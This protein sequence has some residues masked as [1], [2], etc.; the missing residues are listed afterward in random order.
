MGAGGHVPG[1]GSHQRGRVPARLPDAGRGESYTR[2]VL[3]GSGRRPGRRRLLLVCAALLA[4]LG[5]A[6][7]GGAAPAVIVQDSFSRTVATGLGSAPTGGPYTV[8]GKGF[9]VDGSAAVLSLVKGTRIAA[10]GVSA[11]DSDALVRVVFPAIPSAGTDPGRGAVAGDGR[12]GQGD[13]V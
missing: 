12:H 7:P 2:V 5:I 9:S 8:S 11:A 3:T 4:L 10:P 6:A 13:L 1:P